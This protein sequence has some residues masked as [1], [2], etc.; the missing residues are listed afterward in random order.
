MNAGRGCDV[1]WVSPPLS[2]IDSIIIVIYIYIYV[3]IIH[4]SPRLQICNNAL[5]ALPYLRKN[6]ILTVIFF[7]NSLQ[8]LHQQPIVGTDFTQRLLISLFLVFFVVFP[9]L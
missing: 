6:L 2:V 3:Y 1:T 4:Y 5:A 7:L 9:L 8:I